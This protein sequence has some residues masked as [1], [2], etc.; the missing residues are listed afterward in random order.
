MNRFAIPG[1]YSRDSDYFGVAPFGDMV[2]GS[3]NISPKDE[4]M[5]DY[6]TAVYD[7]SNMGSNDY[8]DLN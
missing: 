4:V 1:G 8:S 2:A 6:Y 7:N 3:E 5:D